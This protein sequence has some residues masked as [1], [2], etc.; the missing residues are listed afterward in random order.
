MSKELTNNLGNYND[1]TYTHGRE[2]ANKL[3]AD[4]L[5]YLADVIE[6]EE[7][8]DV[9]LFVNTPINSAMPVDLKLILSYLWGG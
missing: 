7:H 1:L 6:S 8:P 9:F 4:R 5:R 2:T 3:V